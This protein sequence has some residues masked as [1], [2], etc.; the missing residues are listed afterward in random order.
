MLNHI[1][2]MSV[3]TALCLSLVAT[4][5]A[6][7]VSRIYVTNATGVCQGALPV[8]ETAVRK[9]PTALANEG[10]STAFVSCSFAGDNSGNSVTD[11]VFAYVTNRGN[12]ERT[13]NCLLVEGVNI[14]GLGAPVSSPSSLVLTP[15]TSEGFLW[16]ARNVGGTFTNIHNL[17]CALP[18]GVEI[19][20]VGYPFE[21]GAAA[22]P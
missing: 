22:A 13:I 21:D 20:T 9:R 10:T 1:G 3:G 16:F 12:V 6:T 14:P 4:P 18:P 19:S 7:A 17:S 5:R 2:W 15:G 8:F 11:Y